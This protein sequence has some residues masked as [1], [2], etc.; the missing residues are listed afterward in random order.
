VHPRELRSKLDQHPAGKRREQT[1]THAHCFAPSNSTLKFPENRHQEGP[2]E[3]PDDQKEVPIQERRRRFQIRGKYFRLWAYPAPQVTPTP[4]KGAGAG[5]A[6]PAT[7]NIKCSQKSQAESDPGN[8]GRL[9]AIIFHGHP[10]DPAQ[11]LL[12]PCNCTFN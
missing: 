12:R 4:V 2:E 11:P 10:C 1:P 3:D 5:C 6:Q 9:K 7:S 8:I